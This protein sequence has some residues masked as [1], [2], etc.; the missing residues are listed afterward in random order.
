M[1][2]KII[3][4]GYNRNFI[5]TSGSK[6][7]AGGG[8][9]ENYYFQYIDFSNIQIKSFASSLEKEEVIQ[10]MENKKNIIYSPLIG[11]A[12]GGLYNQ[13]HDGLVLNDADNKKY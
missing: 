10:T 7:P 12:I 1:A 13:P 2:E 6:I 4:S 5:L 9:P 3:I 8:M 11:S